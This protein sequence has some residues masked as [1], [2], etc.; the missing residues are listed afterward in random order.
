LNILHGRRELDDRINY[1]YLP[2]TIA[3]YW[4]MGLIGCSRSARWASC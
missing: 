3:Q 4:P 2:P 1:W